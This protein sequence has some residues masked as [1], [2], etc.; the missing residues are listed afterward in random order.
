MS[1]TTQSKGRDVDRPQLLSFLKTIADDFD[2]TLLQARHG[3][4]P[5]GWFWM[6]LLRSL[7]G[8]KYVQVPEETVSKA[9]RFFSYPGTIWAALFAGAAG[10]AIGAFANEHLQPWPQ[11]IAIVLLL[12]TWA[13][14]LRANLLRMLTPGDPCFNANAYRIFR[15][16][17]YLMFLNYMKEPHLSFQS[18]YDWVTLIYEEHNITSI[19]EDYQST[20]RLLRREVEQLQATLTERERD[21]QQSEEDIDLLNSTIELLRDHVEA[22]EEGYNQAID[23]LFRLRRDRGRSLFGPGD[24]RVLSAYSLFEVS[25][26]QLVMVHEQGTTETPEVISL[27]DADYAHYSSVRL[28]N[29]NETIEYA[30]SDREGREVA[31][32]WLELGGREFVYN[33]HYETTDRT[34]FRAIIESK[35]MYRLIRGICFHLEE[36]GLLQREAMDYEEA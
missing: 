21:L 14:A 12:L 18:L 3:F 17:E 33:F 15:P 22:N 34:R 27:G 31:S 1:S 35:E 23:I 13:M 36:R 7:L 10:G 16:T 25:D 30:T 19:I 32:Y 6:L 24:L 4:P 28:V 20:N 11:T 8:I 29:S 5:R 26:D 2:G 9:V